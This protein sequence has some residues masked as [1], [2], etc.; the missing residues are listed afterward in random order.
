MVMTDIWNK[1]S[2]ISS[3]LESFVEGRLPLNENKTNDI[4]EQVEHYW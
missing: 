3:F 2:G 1:S 4:T